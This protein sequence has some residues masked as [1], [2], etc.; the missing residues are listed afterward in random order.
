[1]IEIVELL[2]YCF[3]GPIDMVFISLSLCDGSGEPVQMHVLPKVGNRA[4]IRNR[5]N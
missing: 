5:Y 2:L 3:G 1:M 4:K